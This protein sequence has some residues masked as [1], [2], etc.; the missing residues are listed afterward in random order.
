M[1]NELRELHPEWASWFAVGVVLCCVC[2]VLLVVFRHDKGKDSRA[3]ALT[4]AALSQSL[5]VR[6]WKPG[7]GQRP[8]IYHPAGLQSPLWQPLFICPQDGAVGPPDMDTL[9]VPHCPRCGQVMNVN[10]AVQPY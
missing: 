6:E 8:L 3:S 4:A 1:E 2:I 9:G 5:G 7:M 10:S